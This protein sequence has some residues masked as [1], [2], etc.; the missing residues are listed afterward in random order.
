MTFAQGFCG[1]VQ[2]PP[3]AT[4]GFLTM[5]FQ[6]AV[7]SLMRFRRPKSSSSKRT[8]WYFLAAV[9]NNI[10]YVGS[11]AQMTMSACDEER[12]RDNKEKDIFEL[13]R[14]TVKTYLYFII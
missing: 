11:V 5:A 9:I 6:L 7:T 13:R 3:F 8:E 10:M 12:R 14:W 1:S 2:I 4:V